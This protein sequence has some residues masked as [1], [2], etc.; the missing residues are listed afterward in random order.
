MRVRDVAS[1]E[2]YDSLYVGSDPLTV[3]LSCAARLLAERDRGL[4]TLVVQVGADDGE[5]EPGLESALEKCGSDLVAGCRLDGPSQALSANLSA[6][7]RLVPRESTL[8]GV[9]LEQVRRQARPR[10]VYLPLGL[11]GRVLDR[12]IHEVGARIFRPNS[13]DLFF[14]EE[15]PDALVPGAV[16]LRLAQ[17]GAS[18]PPGVSHL[19][20]AAPLGLILGV[21]R[22]P[23]LAPRL[24]G[25]NERLRTA[26]ILTQLL[27]GTRG[28]R[29]QRAFGPRLQ[30]SVQE[31]NPA[32]AEIVAILQEHLPSLFGSARRMKAVT[33]RYTRSLRQPGYA[34]RYWLLLPERASSAPFVPQDP[35]ETEVGA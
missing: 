14:Y 15:R 21:E 1:L 10:R 3:P 28:W 29:P 24:S 23:H 17:M 7:A 2:R 31:E 26:A 33:N 16:R 20:K 25:L 4:R 8:L 5:G 35:G 6:K 12:E 11:A 13:R 22:A 34:E 9:F 30:P 18:L 19:P 32:A 27:A